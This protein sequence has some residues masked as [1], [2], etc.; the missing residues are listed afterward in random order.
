[1][2]DN[3][4]AAGLSWWEYTITAGFNVIDNVLIRAEYRL[5]WGDNISCTNVG[6]NAGQCNSSGP[7]HYA[8]AEVVYSF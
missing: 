2:G 5:D 1:L 6:G 4:Q 3:N 7:A 8:G